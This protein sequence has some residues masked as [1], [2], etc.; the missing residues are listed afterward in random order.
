MDRL[1][2]R[3]CKAVE[4]KLNLH[5][6]SKINSKI[7]LNKG[8]NFG[9]ISDVKVTDYNGASVVYNFEFN[10]ITK[11]LEGGS[12]RFILNLYL[13]DDEDQLFLQ[14]QMNVEEIIKLDIYE[15]KKYH[16]ENNPSA[17]GFKFMLLESIPNQDPIANIRKNLNL[18]N[19]QAVKQRI[20]KYLSKWRYLHKRGQKMLK[21]KEKYI[22]VHEVKELAF[23]L[24]NI[25]YNLTLKYTTPDENEHLREYILRVYPNNRNLIKPTNE[26]QRYHNLRRI[27]I[28]KANLYIFEKSLKPL[29]HR[30]LILDKLQGTPILETIRSFNQDQLDSFMA[31]LA[32]Y[33]G[34]LH[35][36]RSKKYDSYYVN[37]SIT[38]KL[39]F[40]RYI[41]LEI[42]NTLKNFQK[43][44]LDKE[45]DV[46]TL[47]FYKW[48]RGHRPLLRLD[49]FSL[50]HGDI[51]P[52]NIIVQD[53]KISGLIDWEMSCY[54]DPAQDIGWSLFFFKLYENMK[55]P[56][57][58][59]FSEYWKVCGDYNV[60]ARVRFY[61]IYAAVKLYIY[62]RHTEDKQ[63]EKYAKNIDF[64]TRVKNLVPKYIDSVTHRD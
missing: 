5:F 39:P 15:L 25:V 4:E 40:E 43:M 1:D 57:G 7:L 29:G 3:D 42:K 60:E 19:P 9:S 55:K 24:N 23:G 30:F 38:K 58:L 22:C 11:D 51:R 2:I 50:V 36:H 34:T 53:D 10:Y 17:L 63:P 20:E 61:E 44:G 32:M 33:L 13:A 41:M 45:L 54:S 28:P 46:D 16:F 64:F 48:F 47:Y 26:A 14:D 27:D 31:D 18:K 21:R 62:T 52:S 59:F 37:E 6:D 8:E 49:A 56:R 35:S 12:R